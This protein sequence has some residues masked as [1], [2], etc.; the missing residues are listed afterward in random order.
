MERE[1]ERER[2]RESKRASERETRE[3]ACDTASSDEHQ[4]GGRCRVSESVCR[5]CVCVRACACACW[6]LLLPLPMNDIFTCGFA[7]VRGFLTE[8][9]L[10]SDVT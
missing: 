3:E 5:V 2:E 9:G 1:R 10:S 8:S 7:V 6:L 4:V